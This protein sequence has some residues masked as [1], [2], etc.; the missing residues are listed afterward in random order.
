MKRTKMIS[1][2]AALVLA[3]SASVPA[4][5]AAN[6][7]LVVSYTTNTSTTTAAPA[8]QTSSVTFL[9]MKGAMDLALKEVPGVLKS[10]EFD[11][12]DNGSL[13]YSAEVHYNSKEYDLEFSAT[14]GT[15]YQNKQDTI[16]WDEAIPAGSYISYEKAAEA[17]LGQVKGGFVSKLKLESRWND[18]VVY[19]AEVW[20]G[21]YEYTVVIDADNGTVLRSGW[22]K[23][24]DASY[25][26]KNLAG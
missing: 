22:E 1:I 12:E 10:I 20:L 9:S 13:R 11:I 24:S 16:E 15:V 19:D 2:A 4:F 21:D 8:A 3:V 17:A 14:D 25:Y 5:A 18:G 7:R 6:D 26:T 23:E